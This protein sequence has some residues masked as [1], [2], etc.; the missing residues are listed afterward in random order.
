MEESIK[1]NR[2]ARKH[3]PITANLVLGG[4]AFSVAIIEV[5]GI[6]PSI[7]CIGKKRRDLKASLLQVEPK[8]GHH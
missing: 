3:P 2:P 1:A 5:R 4:D 8:N 7:G 6:L